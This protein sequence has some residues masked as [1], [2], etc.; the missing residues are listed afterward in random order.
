MKDTAMQQAIAKI[1]ESI[2]KEDSLVKSL[3]LEESLEMLESLLPLE[4]EQIIEAYDTGRSDEET[5]FPVALNGEDFYTS[6]FNQ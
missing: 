4:K 6:T 2:K 5:R 1:K 3:I